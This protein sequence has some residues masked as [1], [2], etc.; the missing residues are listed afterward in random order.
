[1]LA[2]MKSGID[3]MAL[4]LNINDNCFKK[5]SVEMSEDIGGFVKIHLK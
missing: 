1:M 5:I 4:A 2:T 3:G